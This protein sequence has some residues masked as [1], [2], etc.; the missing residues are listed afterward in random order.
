MKYVII[1]TDRPDGTKSV[2]PVILPDAIIHSEMS[3]ATMRAI[4]ESTGLGNEYGVV[5]AGFIGLDGVTCHGESESIG[6]NSRGKLDA[7]RILVGDAG[8]FLPD[9][10]IESFVDQ[11]TARKKG[12]EV[13]V[14]AVREAVQKGFD[15]WAAKT[16]N[17]KW[18]KRV[19]GTPIPNDV[20]MCIQTAV[21][22]ALMGEDNA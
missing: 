11:L 20:V 3:R 18:A 10:V 22:R 4:R 17:K 2:F 19:D 13:D 8:M 15:E 6:V 12:P 5:S 14:A 1:Q 7:A 21:A 9:N 16:H